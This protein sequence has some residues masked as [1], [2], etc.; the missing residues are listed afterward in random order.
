MLYW[1]WQKAHIQE[2]KGLNPAVYW[3][4]VS[5]ASYNILQK[6]KENV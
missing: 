1:L 6:K 2:V 3:L 5:K 4:D